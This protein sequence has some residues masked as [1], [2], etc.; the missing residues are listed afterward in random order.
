MGLGKTIQIAAFLNTLFTKFGNRGPFLILVPLSLIQQWNRELSDWTNL[1]VVSYVGN[2]ADRAMI[3]EYDFVYPQDRPRRIPKNRYYLRQCHKSIKHP[4]EKIWMAQ[5]ILTTPKVFLSSDINELKSID[6][7]TLIFD[8]AHNGLKNGVSKLSISMR[9][10][11]FRFQHSILLTGTPIQNDMSEL[12]QLLNFIA[13]SSFCDHDNFLSLYGD[14]KEKKEVEH[15]HDVIRPYILRRLKGDVE[16]DLPLKEETIVEVEL[17]T[18]QKKYY[19]AIFENNRKFMVKNSSAAFTANLFMEL[20]KCCNHPF[21][22]KGVEEHV[23]GMQPI[24]DELELLVKTSGKMVLLDKLLPKLKNGGHRVLIFSQFKIMLN[25]IEDYLHLSGVNYERIDGG[26]KGKNRF[27]AVERFQNDDSIL[28]FL[29]TTTAGGVGLNLTAADTCIIFDSDFNPQNDLQAQARCHRIG[30]KKNVQVYRFLTTKTIEMKYFEFGSRKLGL[31]K[32][33]LQGVEGQDDTLISAKETELLLRHGAYHL[34]SQPED[35]LDSESKRFMEEDIDTILLRRS[36]K[37]VH[38]E[39]QSSSTS[40][41][42]ATFISGNDDKNEFHYDCDVDLED[43]DFWSKVFGKKDV[44]ELNEVDP[45]EQEREQS[46]AVLEE[47]DVLQTEEGF[48]TNKNVRTI[49]EKDPK[50]TPTKNFR[51]K[52]MTDEKNPRSSKT[53]MEEVDL[54]ENKLISS[55][56][57]METSKKRK[58]GRPR[59]KIEYEDDRKKKQKLVGRKEKSGD[60]QDL[61]N[62]SLSQHPVETNKKR[63]VGRP[64]KIVSDR[65]ARN[66]EQRVGGPKN[67]AKSEKDQEMKTSTMSAVKKRGRPRKDTS[68]VNKDFVA[69]RSPRLKQ[70]TS[71][72]SLQHDSRI[73]IPTSKETSRQVST[74]EPTNQP[75]TT[76]TTATKTAVKKKRSQPEHVRAQKMI[77]HLQPQ[78]QVADARSQQANITQ[79]QVQQVQAVAQAQKLMAGLVAGSG[80]T[81]GTMT[82]TTASTEATN[83]YRYKD[84]DIAQQQNENDA[85]LPND[86]KKKIRRR[87]KHTQVSKSKGKRRS[88][89][90]GTS[91]LLQ[92]AQEVDNKSVQKSSK[93]DDKRRRS[94]ES[95]LDTSGISTKSILES[96]FS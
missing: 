50:A 52:E 67:K 55:K 96:M 78:V 80:G 23:N 7:D 57:K 8:E 68:S 13:P 53:T 24:T 66:D 61:R 64:R 38:N 36:K 46:G 62:A 16:K 41:Q 21:L 6:F 71:S 19:R 83:A 49:I 9:D 45:R 59:K 35:E 72:I 79:G 43:P 51:G 39:A 75:T 48:C 18:L 74:S 91:M 47:E 60:K 26:I 32:V 29:L 20:R 31:D 81:R 63:K 73:E 93:N 33:V 17:T 95:R 10:E 90:H 65:N 4:R 12:W 28:V 44:Y 2:A 37:K 40:F 94:S 58:V 88:L 1:N 22:L 25:I 69:R 15:L 85:D 42:K 27:D 34:L 54:Q 86:R 84:D 56:H 87:D 76:I 5:V 82:L 11:N 92:I 70:T 89:T 14:M 77:Q 3:R 30:Q